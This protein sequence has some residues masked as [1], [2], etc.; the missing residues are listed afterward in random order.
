MAGILPRSASF[1]LTNTGGTK[2]ILSIPKIV[3]PLLAVSSTTS[4]G[5]GS[6]EG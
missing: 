6:R 4:R 5:R 3:I 1:E 2:P